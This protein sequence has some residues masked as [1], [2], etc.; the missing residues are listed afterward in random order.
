MR[1]GQR[2]VIIAAVCVVLITGNSCGGGGSQVTTTLNPSP[3]IQSISPS[4]AAAGTSALSL[5]VSGSNFLPTSAIQWN[6]STRPTTVVSSSQLTAAISAQ[7]LSS[8]G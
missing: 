6:G 8:P 1:S 7:D 5:T 4:T 3:Q 2:I